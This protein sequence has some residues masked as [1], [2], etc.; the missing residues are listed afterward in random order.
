[1]RRSLSSSSTSL[2]CMIRTLSANL[3]IGRREMRAPRAASSVF[4]GGPTCRFPALP[5]RRIPLSRT[6]SGFALNVRIMHS[7]DVLEELKLRRIHLG[8]GR[9][10][11]QADGLTSL[12]LWEFPYYAVLPLDHREALAVPCVSIASSGRSADSPIRAR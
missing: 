10:G 1:M 5:R 7:S 12:R 9:A 6:P 11:M 8:F 4:I 2:L 3:G